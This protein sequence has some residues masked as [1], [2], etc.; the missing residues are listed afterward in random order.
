MP[1]V[2]RP[3]PCTSHRSIACASA[4]A[5]RRA[6]SRHQQAGADR[7]SAANTRTLV[8]RDVAHARQVDGRGPHERRD[9]SPRHPDAA[10]GRGRQQRA[11]RQPHGRRAGGG[12]RR[13]PSEWHLA[14]PPTA[15]DSDRLATLTRDQQDGG[16]RAE[17]KQQTPSCAADDRDV[18]RR[19]DRRQSPVRAPRVRRCHSPALAADRARAR[20]LERYANLACHREFCGRRPTP[21]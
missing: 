19:D 16:N 9:R 18:E 20:L 17:Q 14:H 3:W 1:R 7:I 2:R 5:T 12:S 4:D 10:S 8:E 6:G 21:R 15:R 11:A 13:A